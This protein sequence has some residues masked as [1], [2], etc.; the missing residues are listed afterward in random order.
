MG[1]DTWVYGD[2]TVKREKIYEFTDELRKEGIEPKDFSFSLDVCTISVNDSLRHTDEWA[3]KVC[4]IFAKYVE[5]GV[6]NGDGED[7]DDIWQIVFDGKGGWGFE[8]GEIIYGNILDVFEDRYGHYN[9][10]LKKELDKIRVIRK[11]VR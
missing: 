10:G 3:A 5:A 8:Q 6:I 1:Y 2:L 11:L 9:P 4:P 7:R